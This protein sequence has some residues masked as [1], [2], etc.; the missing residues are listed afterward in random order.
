MRDS[1]TSQKWFKHFPW[2]FPRI[3]LLGRPSQ[4]STTI[5][6]LQ[7]GPAERGHVKNRQKVS[8][9]FSTLFVQGKKRQ[10]SSKNVKKFFDTYRQISRVTILPAPFWGAL[11]PARSARV[12]GNDLLVMCSLVLFVCPVSFNW[13]FIPTKSSVNLLMARKNFT[14]NS[15]IR[16]GHT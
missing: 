2:R 1:K 3:I 10:K 5:S 4:E 8:N 12:A 14:L 7:K 9:S 15:L 11:I 13:L 6:G 16:M